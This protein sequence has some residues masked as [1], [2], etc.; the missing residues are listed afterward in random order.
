MQ[1][2]EELFTT[3]T[4]TAEVWNI[5]A[6]QIVGIKFAGRA[7]DAYSRKMRD[8]YMIRE[9]STEAYRGHVFDAALSNFVL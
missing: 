2:K 3:A 9:N 1:R 8:T 6:G 4:T 5:P 7:Y